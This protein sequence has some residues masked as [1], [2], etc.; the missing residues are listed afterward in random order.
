MILNDNGDIKNKSLLQYILP[1]KN[2]DHKKRWIQ[3][4][5]GFLE[6]FLDDIS[7]NICNDYNN[8]HRNS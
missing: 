2:R 1:H 7:V 8:L 4:C 5:K 3:N 6:L